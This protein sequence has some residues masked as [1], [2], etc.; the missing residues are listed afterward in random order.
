MSEDLSVWSTKTRKPTTALWG[1]HFGTDEGKE[2]RM[3]SVLSVKEN[4]R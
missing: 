3:T 1:G 4:V 2:P